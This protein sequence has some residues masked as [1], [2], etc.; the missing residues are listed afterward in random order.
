MH[1]GGVINHDRIRQHIQKDVAVYIPC[2]IILAQGVD[3]AFS[4]LVSSTATR[5][6][7]SSHVDVPVAASSSSAGSSSNH[8]AVAGGCSSRLSSAAADP[9]VADRSSSSCPAVAGDALSSSAEWPR[10][11]PNIVVAGGGCDDPWAGRH[12]VRGDEDGNTCIVAGK[13]SMFKSVTRLEWHLSSG[14][15]YKKKTNK[16]LR[17]GRGSSWPR[18]CSGGHVAAGRRW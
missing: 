2:Q 10:M 16:S 11:S 8:P 4:G 3:P 9:A 14:G 12:V 7:V 5:R 17:H 15:Q 6:H 13:R 18:W 1:T